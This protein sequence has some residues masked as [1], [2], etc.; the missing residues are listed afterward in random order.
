MDVPIQELVLATE[1]I[2]DWGCAL[3]K[4]KIKLRSSKWKIIN[5]NS[6]IGSKLISLLLKSKESYSCKL[7]AQIIWIPI[8]H[9]MSA[10]MNASVIKIFAWII[11]FKV[12]KS[13]SGN[14]VYKKSISQIRFNKKEIGENRNIIKK[15]RSLKNLKLNWM[16]NWAI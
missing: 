3:I 14:Y 5:I 15:L 11:W 2:V 1:I 9:L 13:I 6:R 8:S 10:V 16:G 4:E 12:K 7:E